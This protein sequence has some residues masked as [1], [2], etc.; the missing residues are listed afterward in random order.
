[1]VIYACACRGQTEHG[2]T[3]FLS[4]RSTRTHATNGAFRDGLLLGKG[5][6]KR[7][8]EAHISAGRWAAD[9]DRASFTEGY[10]QGYA[11]SSTARAFRRARD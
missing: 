3:E 5:E 7:G 10:Q 4:V 11:E 9:Q 2:Y 1:M 8:A 6:A